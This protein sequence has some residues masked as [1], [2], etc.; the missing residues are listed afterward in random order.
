VL[1]PLE[2]LVSVVHDTATFVKDGSPTRPGGFRRA[3]RKI[4][5]PAEAGLR[6]RLVLF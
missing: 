6:M 4:L 1:C 2:E 5:H 3:A